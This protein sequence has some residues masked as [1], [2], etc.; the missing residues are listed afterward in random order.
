MTDGIAFLDK[1]SL[2]GIHPQGYEIKNFWRSLWFQKSLS[3]LWI[4]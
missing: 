1:K 4:S 3:G 2:D